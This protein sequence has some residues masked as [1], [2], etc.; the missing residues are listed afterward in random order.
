MTTPKRWAILKAISEAPPF[1]LTEAEIGAAHAP[2]HIKSRRQWASD[3][4]FW[5]ECEAGYATYKRSGN[6][7]YWAATAHG[8]AA[9]REHEMESKT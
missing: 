7:I 6:R 8:E 3:A 2:A 4:M 5:L 9:L 1:T